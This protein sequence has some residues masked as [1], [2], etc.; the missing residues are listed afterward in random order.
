[1]GLDNTT[2][3]VVIA[4]DGIFD[5][6]TSR[7]SNG[8][9]AAAVGSLIAGGTLIDVTISGTLTQEI[10]RN[11]L[12]EGTITNQGTIT[13]TDDSTN[14]IGGVPDTRFH[15][16][17]VVTLT[18]GG[19]VLLTGAETGFA[20]SGTLINVDNTIEAG[21][22]AMINVPVQ[23]GVMGVL[24][25]GDGKRLQLDG[26][27]SGGTLTSHAGGLITTGANGKLSDL[28]LTGT[29]TN[30]RHN[31]LLLEGTITN[32]GVLTMETD[33]TN[34][35]GNIPDTRFV[36]NSAV[37]LT[38]A[39]EVVLTGSETGFTGEGVLT[40]VNNTIRGFG[41]IQVTTIN[42]GTIAVEGGKL[43]LESSI[44]ID[45]SSGAITIAADAGLNMGTGMILGGT[46]TATLGST[47][48]DGT[49]N[50]ITL[51]GT[52]TEE[53]NTGTVLAGTI[54]NQGTLTFAI[55]GTN[56]IGGVPD[57]R[58]S[59]N[60]QATLSGGGEIVLTGNETGF[61]GSG[62]LTNANNTIRG[63][64]QIQVT[65]IN[66]G[67]IIAE[68]GQLQVL[69][70]LTGSGE[71]QISA[72]AELEFNA[73]LL[74]MN[75][76]SADPAG[77]FDFNGSRLEFNEFV[78]DFTHDTGT[79]SPAIEQGNAT[80]T[81]NY[82]MNSNATLEIE[83]AGTAAGEFDVLQVSGDA[84]VDGTLH[85]QAT[86]QI[87]ALG[88]SQTMDV[89]TAGSLNG[90]FDNLPAAGDHIGYGVFLDA[91]NFD[92]AGDRVELP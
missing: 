20:G 5:L 49:L 56:N 65:T 2:G 39:G 45:N 67:T 28:V 3:D 89:L 77:T 75:K 10:N 21:T 62:T 61:A 26:A 78:G 30:Q 54:I 27:V 88:T 60:E 81:G 63:F 8:N 25:I 51:S 59:I 58:F 16:D 41:Q 14:N 19:T 18:G 31:A 24:S 6:G 11:T 83:I 42:Q 85:L 91:L 64:G 82:T 29:L 23:N 87:A 79:L 72:G 33:S 46:I 80:L 13:F 66:Q 53:I 76:I 34:N 36:V 68:G 38:G 17:T 70:D 35:I 44:E 15:L 86:Q 4:A 90:T 32:Q 55:D 1:M 71:I 9:L 43:S 50:G 57:T 92:T 22:S 74:S 84:N 12:W 7:L 48:R 52:L 40:N 47:V 37:T 73:S 69:R